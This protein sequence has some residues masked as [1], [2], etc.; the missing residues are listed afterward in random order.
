VSIR[1]LPGY[2]P[3]IEQFEVPLESG[4]KEFTFFGHSRTLSDTA[5]YE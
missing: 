4:L 5:S 1:F 2:V 3:G